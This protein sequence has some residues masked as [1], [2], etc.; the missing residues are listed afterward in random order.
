MA[1]V[2]LL[3]EFHISVLAPRGLRDAEYAAIHRT[4]AG[5]R[6]RAG[7]RRAIRKVQWQYGS[8]AR[9]TLKLST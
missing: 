3:D 5:A 1:R 2:L 4:L 6:F 9:A 8:L 7:L